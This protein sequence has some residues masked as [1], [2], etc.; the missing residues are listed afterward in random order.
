LFLYQRPHTSAPQLGTTTHTAILRQTAQNCQGHPVFDCD[1]LK[2]SHMGLSAHTR[3]PLGAQ[4][5]IYKLSTCCSLSREVSDHTPAAK[6]QSTGSA[7]AKC[8]RTETHALARAGR[9]GTQ[10]GACRCR[11]SACNT[12]GLVC[13][14]ASSK[15]EMSQG[16]GGPVTRTQC[17]KAGAKRDRST[18]PPN[19]LS[20]GWIT[21]AQALH[22]LAAA[23][24]EHTHSQT[25]HSRVT[26]HQ[27]SGYKQSHICLS[28]YRAW[29]CASLT[30]A[31]TNQ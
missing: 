31:T 4:D 10:L 27:H 3:T 25:K 15:G 19:S 6:Q 20:T 12:Q 1:P 21:C 11:T 14:G 18:G 23:V 28:I 13:W 29:V 22:T 16:K 24:P 9:S 17:T 2:Q 8:S 30:K 7:A 5:C 26:A